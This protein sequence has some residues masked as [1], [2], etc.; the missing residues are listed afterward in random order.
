MSESKK[1]IDLKVAGAPTSIHSPPAAAS[2]PAAQSAA[3]AARKPFFITIPHSGEKVPTEASWLIGLSERL[4]MYDVDRY[5]DRLYEPALN[6]LAI[7]HIKTE[8]HRYAV[9][10]NRWTNDVD[11]DSVE[12]A[13]NPSG[14]YTRGLHWS[15]T[16]SGEKLMTSPMSR[17]VHEKL[18][19]FYFEPFHEQVRALYLAF[20][21]R[22]F[23][24]IY[25]LDAHSMPSVGTGQHRDPGQM[26]ADIVIS[27]G[28]G[29]TCRSEFLEL[30]VEAYRAAG[31]SI[32]INWPYFGG[33]VTET[34]G[35]P[36]AGHH[37]LQ[38]EVNR[39]LYMNEETKLL[40]PVEARDIADRVGTAL[41]KILSG[42]E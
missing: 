6:R 11:A 13:A 33:R 5:V 12:G 18:V 16:T 38:V 19:R 34:Y 3:A 39:K 10:L 2:L 28:K 37:A 20:R 32:A 25:H 1:G 7:P 8:W 31:F 26:R 40:L 14:G 42:L 9:D 30:V 22:G 41:E 36:A 23:Q 21:E 27:D 35:R 17:A 4:L 29:S 15:A 24:E